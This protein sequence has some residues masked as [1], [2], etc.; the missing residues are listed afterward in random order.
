MKALS[1]R[2]PWLWTILERGKRI[3]NRRWTTAYRGPLL[4]HSSAAPRTR[5]ELEEFNEDLEAIFG[6]AVAFGVP[7]R[8]S[9]GAGLLAD[10]WEE[11]R[12]KYLDGVTGRYT[13]KDRLLRGGIVGIAELVDV[14]PRRHLDARRSARVPANWAEE[15]QRDFDARVAR[16][17]MRHAPERLD[18]RWSFPGQY[19]LVLRRVRAVPFQ[20][21]KGAL[22]LFAVTEPVI[23]RLPDEVRP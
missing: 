22:G 18:T 17:N 9:T 13:P 15:S 5:L 14:L 3:E 7:V 23:S 11:F 19:G 12:G 1:L 8:A 10:D 2:Q 4:L 21:L 16:F 6:S 20:P